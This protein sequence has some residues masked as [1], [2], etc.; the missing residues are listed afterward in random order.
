MG[1][2]IWDLDSRQVWCYECQ[3]YVDH[4]PCQ[5]QAMVNFG[6][7]QD[8]APLDSVQLPKKVAEFDVLW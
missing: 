7:V 1:P 8:G 2:Q 4:A 6:W 5:S 3:A